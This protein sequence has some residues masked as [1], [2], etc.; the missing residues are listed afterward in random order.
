MPKLASFLI[1]GLALAACRSEPTP[2]DPALVPSVLNYE[3]AGSGEAVVLLQ[4]A[5]LPMQ[6]WDEEFRRFAMEFRVIRF[7]VRGFGGSAA[8]D[9][10]RYQS[11]DDL[12]ALLDY[13]NIKSAHLVGLSLGG[14][15]ALDFALEHPERVRSL[16]LAGPG[17]SGYRWDEAALDEWFAE[18]AA[19]RAEGDSLK[20][21]EHWLETP[22]MA[23]AMRNPLVA[24][25]LAQLARA[26]A[27]VWTHSDREVSL[28]PPAVERLGEIRTPTLV[29]LGERDVPDEHRIADLIVEGVPGAKRIIFPGVGHVINMET[30]EAFADATLG[31]LRKQ[32]P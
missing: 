32:A 20:A 28:S 10:V 22:F 4:G 5:N 2:L 8:R 15:V 13:L 27:R 6:M 21:A 16:V 23:P 24:P 26:N 1:A 25:R 30:P 18:I 19:A 11:H 14:R 7:D 29:L 17:L 9:S 12:R 3:S 31:F